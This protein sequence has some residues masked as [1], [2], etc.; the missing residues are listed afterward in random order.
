M[1]PDELNTKYRKFSNILKSLE[2]ELILKW[3]IA[4]LTEIQDEFDKIAWIVDF[5]DYL[6]DFYCCFY[7]QV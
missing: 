6:K 2:I 5:K 3:D 1:T 7:L 4:K